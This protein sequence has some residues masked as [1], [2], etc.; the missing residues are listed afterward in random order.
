MK[1]CRCVFTGVDLVSGTKLA[2]PVE[3]AA[4]GLVEK[5]VMGPHTLDGC[6]RRKA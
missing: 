5:T 4:V 1:A 2:A 3:K 6:G